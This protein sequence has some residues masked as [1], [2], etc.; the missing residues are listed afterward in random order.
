M[1]PPVVAGAVLGAKAAKFGVF[2]VRY[3]LRWL[4]Y[5][6]VKY[7]VLLVAR[8]TPPTK[9]YR[10]VARL[11]NA[12]QLRMSKGLASPAERRNV[13]RI[14]RE[15]FRAPDR[16][17]SAAD[18]EALALF[19][20]NVSAAGSPTVVHG[21][22]H[23]SGPGGAAT[24]QRGFAEG[25]KMRLAAF[26]AKQALKRAEFRRARALPPPPL[27]LK[28]EA[29]AFGGSILLMAGVYAWQH[30]DEV[31]EEVAGAREGAHAALEAAEARAEAALGE[32]EARAERVDEQL[33]LVMLRRRRPEQKQQREAAA[34]TLRE[35]AQP[36]LAGV[37]PSPTAPALEPGP[38]AQSQPLQPL[39]PQQQQ[40]QR[41]QQQ[42][43]RRQQQQQQQ[44]QQQ[45]QEEEE[46]LAAADLVLAQLV[47]LE[48]R[49]AALEAKI[50]LGAIL[51]AES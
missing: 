2:A 5:Y 33:E 27:D 22:F 30:P 7:S 15:A 42:Q 26:A 4:P 44:Q 46:G 35:A 10:F 47:Q 28:S 14:I 29:L 39:Q 17:R 50:K 32:A 18:S 37:P 25:Q 41:Q 45:T 16:I 43:Q 13:R 6:A 48:A 23:G 8:R 11:V 40:Q 21:G 20:H 38:A 19:L 1:A 34:A 51:D 12:Q 24:A 49:A 9:A 36:P 3:G 31:F